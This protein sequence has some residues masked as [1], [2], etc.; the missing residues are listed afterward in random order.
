MQLREILYQIEQSNNI[1]NC[2]SF[3]NLALY[4]SCDKDDKRY[5]N[6]Q[7][8]D[9][10]GRK[11]FLDNL[12]KNDFLFMLNYYYQNQS[13]FNF[14][15]N[16]T[17]KNTIIAF[18][19]YQDKID[20]NL[21]L[22]EFSNPIIYRILHSISSDILEQLQ[23]YNIEN[24]SLPIK[25]SIILNFLK[26]EDY[27]LDDLEYIVERFNYNP[28]FIYE[29]LFLNLDK[30]TCIDYLIYKFGFTAEEEFIEYLPHFFDLH[31]EQYFNDYDNEIVE[32][33]IEYVSDVIADFYINYNLNPTPYLNGIINIFNYNNYDIKPE[34]FIKYPDY[35]ETLIQIIKEYKEFQKN[36]ELF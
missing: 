30:D 18:K 33:F 35:K 16:T 23:S 2:Y 27:T 20:Y 5:I 12:L 1:E 17:F 9:I 32:P 11:T 21:F 15:D 29:I 3:L 25:K 14:S 24:D 28:S 36:I 10:D 34:C 26:N 19:Y 8:L 13:L 7:I 31:I 22:D 4:Q 6:N